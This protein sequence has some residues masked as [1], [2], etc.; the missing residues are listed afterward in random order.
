M[1]LSIVAI[2]PNQ[3]FIYGIVISICMISTR[4]KQYPVGK[5][6]FEENDDVCKRIN[7][8]PCE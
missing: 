3:D 1:F 2:S 6:L 5:H 8:Q 4:N 7:E